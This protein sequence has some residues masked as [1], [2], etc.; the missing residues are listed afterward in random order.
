VLRRLGVEAD[1][2]RGQVESIEGWGLGDAG[3]SVPFTPRMKRVLEGSSR[4]SQS[5][6]HRYVGTDHL[7]VGLLDEREGIS[8]RVLLNL[9]IDP[10]EALQ[11]AVE[12]LRARGADEDDPLA[13]RTARAPVY[14]HHAAILPLFTRVRRR[15]STASLTQNDLPS[16]ARRA[17]VGERKGYKVAQNTSEGSQKWAKIDVAERDNA[18]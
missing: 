7:L 1:E 6:G 12:I 16:T 14:P 11:N 3:D 2:A 17:H 15:L 4:A 13:Q 5:Q 8:A 10:D 9:G 18:K